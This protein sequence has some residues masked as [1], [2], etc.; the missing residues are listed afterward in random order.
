MMQLAYIFANQEVKWDEKHGQKM[1]LK[2][3]VICMSPDVPEF[4]QSPTAA[5]LAGN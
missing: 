4:L 2:R 1:A 3:P 5:P